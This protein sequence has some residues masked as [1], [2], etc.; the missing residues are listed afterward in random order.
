[1]K[2]FELKGPSPI[3]YF[4][5]AAVELGLECLANWKD[6]SDTFFYGVFSS[7]GLVMKEDT[8]RCFVSYVS[9]DECK[10]ISEA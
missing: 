2:I 4:I 10:P 7:E 8:Y 1:M 9:T 6:G 5:L 3:F